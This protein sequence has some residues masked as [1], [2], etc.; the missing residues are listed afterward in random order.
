MRNKKNTAQPYKRTTF[1]Q[2]QV[3]KE[4]VRNGK[5]PIQIIGNVNKIDPENPIDIKVI[6]ILTK[7]KNQIFLH[8]K[9]LMPCKFFL[10]INSPMTSFNPFW[11]KND[12]TS[13]NIM[14][15]SEE[16]MLDLK[17]C[18]Q[19]GS[20]IGIDKTFNLGACIVMLHVFCIKVKNF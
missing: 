3:I 11:Q 4:G 8:N 9:T 18:M 14:C 12:N 17:S 13:P 2:K 15:Y 10:L 16:Q 1:P 20:I 7:T 5:K 19:N 6:R